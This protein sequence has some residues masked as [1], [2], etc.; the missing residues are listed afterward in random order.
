MLSTHYVCGINSL[1]CLLRRPLRLLTAD[2]LPLLRLHRARRD[3]WRSL[4]D[5]P[6]TFVAGNGAP[7]FCGTCGV[8]PLDNM[9]WRLLK[10]ALVDG[11]E[12]CPRGDIVRAMIGD[13]I[14]DK[15]DAAVEAVGAANAG[16]TTRRLHSSKSLRTRPHRSTY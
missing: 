7:Y 3:R 16:T 5:S 14:E 15:V 6:L 13:P 4:L 9:P 2:L 10:H 11:L 1:R 8:T 12:R